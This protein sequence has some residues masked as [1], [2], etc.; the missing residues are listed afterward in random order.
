MTWIQAALMKLLPSRWGESLRRESE[1]WKIVC[2]HC[3]A[4]RSVWQ[5][6]GIRW[7]AKSKGK[8]VLVHC[9][10]CGRN[11]WARVEWDPELEP[12]AVKKGGSRGS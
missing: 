8:R 11:R 12:T 4:S 9:D 7:K 6:G 3:G 2:N 10:R 5:A 1:G